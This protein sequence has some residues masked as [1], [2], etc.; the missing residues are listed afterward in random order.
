[1]LMS[2]D[3]TL[4]PYPDLSVL[5]QAFDGVHSIIYPGM[6]IIAMIRMPPPSEP[7]VR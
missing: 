2:T 3:Q 6:H 5:V 4:K 7:E 1:M